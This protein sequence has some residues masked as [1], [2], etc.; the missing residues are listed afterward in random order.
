M[1]SVHDLSKRYSY[2]F[3]LPTSLRKA[4]STSFDKNDPYHLTAFINELIKFNEWPWD[5]ITMYNCKRIEFL[6]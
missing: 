2:N 5:D 3:S 4:F 6:I 1:F